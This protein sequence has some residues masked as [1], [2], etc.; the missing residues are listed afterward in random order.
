MNRNIYS[1]NNFVSDRTSEQSASAEKMRTNLKVLFDHTTIIPFKWKTKYGCFYC[2][3]TYTEYAKFRKHTK[4]HGPSSKKTIKLKTYREVLIDVS[5]IICELCQT[6]FKSRAV[7]VDHLI[8]S[9]LIVYNKNVSLPFRE[10]R[11]SDLTCLL[12]DQ[13]FSNFQLLARHVRSSHTDRFECNDC[14]RCFTKA[15]NISL[16]LRTHHVSKAFVCIKCSKQ[17]IDEANLKK[18]DLREHLR[19]C[20]QCDAK[21]EKEGNGKKPSSK[22]HSDD[23][24]SKCRYC[25]KELPSVSEIKYYV[26]SELKDINQVVTNDDNQS[27]KKRINKNALCNQIRRNIQYVLNMSTAVPFKHKGKFSCFYCSQRFSNF[28]ELIS[29]TR[30]EHPVCELKSKAM[31]RCKGEKACIKLDINGLACKLCQQSMSDLKS[32]VDHAI[33]QH[34]A[35]YDKSVPFNDCFD[36]FHLT[37]GRILCP[38]CQEP[39]A[40]FAS[41]LKHLGAEHNHHKA[42]CAYCGRGFRSTTSLAMHISYAHTGTCEC[43]V[44]NAK[45]KNSA[46]LARHMARFH[47]AKDFKCPQCPELFETIYKKQNHLIKAHNVGHKCAYCGKMFTRNS[48][49]MNHVRRTHLKER[50]VPCSVCHVKFFDTYHMKLHMVKH[51]GMRRFR[52]DVCGKTFLRVRNLKS[53]M[54]T[55]KKGF[56]Q[57]GI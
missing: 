23:I 33:A 42:V 40:Y 25:S 50:T 32:F 27:S 29:H 7:V 55:H 30:A 44:C 34:D 28:D 21:F 15:A 38:E 57:E 45:C 31:Q 2:N 56:L 37:Q 41:L 53:H 43:S 22:E 47:D 36:T 13:Q 49:M 39:F 20:A 8:K 9:H 19:L 10:Y 12:C 5:E 24:C 18:H 16:H 3:E 26:P 14:G 35:D 46:A 1:K 51:E 54:D 11:L 48:F 52:C 4:S 6:E 17:F